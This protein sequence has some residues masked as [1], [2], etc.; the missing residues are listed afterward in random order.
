MVALLAQ[1]LRARGTA[2][3]L[4]DPFGT[5]DS[6]G[7]L[8]KAT[9]ELWKDD[10]RAAHAWLRLQGVTEIVLWGHRLGALLATEL[11]HEFDD[12]Q[13]LLLWSPVPAGDRFLTQ[14]LRLRAAASL[15]RGEQ[16]STKQLR[17]IL[18]KQGTLA[19]A[20][21]VISEEL[22]ASIEGIKLIDTTPPASVHTEWF[23]VEASASAQPRVATTKV[24]SAWMAAGCSVHTTLLPGDPF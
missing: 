22:A 14:F 2:T 24:V 4:I 1:T 16:E 9:W 12:V 19:V 20:G 18:Q 17:E 6:E 21:C 10:F 3:L 7:D 5:G 15:M 11:A 13:R 23:D 8:E